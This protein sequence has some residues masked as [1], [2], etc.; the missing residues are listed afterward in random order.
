MNV[1]T[2]L[3]D[4]KGVQT[5]VYV[6]LKITSDTQ[7]LSALDVKNVRCFTYFQFSNL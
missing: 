1:H 5:G 3:R 4:E 7:K 2:V 6:Q